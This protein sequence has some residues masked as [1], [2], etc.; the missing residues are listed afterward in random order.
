MDRSSWLRSRLAATVL[1]VVLGALIVS[2]WL[3][4]GQ[5]LGGRWADVGTRSVAV[6]TE[7]YAPID[8]AAVAGSQLQEAS[9]SQVDLRIND[10]PDEAA[11][12]FR[13]AVITSA[14]S[15][16]LASLTFL[17]MGYRVV[18]GVP[19]GRLFSRL[20]TG[21][22]LILLIGGVLAPVADALGSFTA[23]NSVEGIHEARPGIMTGDWMF[24]FPFTFDP[25]PL[26]LGLVFLLLAAVLSRGTAHYDDVKNLV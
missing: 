17:V 13:T 12:W 14:L 19:F 9:F 20:V 10:I 21:S 16:G 11:A 8:T 4:N 26:A 7:G 25:V 1:V 23:I 6:V 24:Y 18:R 2:V 22:G 15:M 5:S 3:F